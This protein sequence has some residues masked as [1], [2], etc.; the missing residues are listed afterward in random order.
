MYIDLS[1]LSWSWL[2][3]VFFAPLLIL[4]LISIC[5]FTSWISSKI[6]NARIFN[7]NLFDIFKKKELI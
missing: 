5:E 4:P 3:M 6:S 7:F 2:A 1:F